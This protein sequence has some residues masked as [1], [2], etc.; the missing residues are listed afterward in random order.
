[1]HVLDAVLNVSEKS[2]FIVFLLTS[3]EEIP[4]G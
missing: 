3:W 1:M 4:C 2:Y